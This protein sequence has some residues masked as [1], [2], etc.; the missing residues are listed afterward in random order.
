MTTK[1][2]SV[3][4]RLIEPEKLFTDSFVTE[5]IDGH[6]VNVTRQ[7]STRK[8]KRIIYSDQVIIINTK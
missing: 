1:K 8:V 5:N 4:E 6:K 3:V 7:V 2:V